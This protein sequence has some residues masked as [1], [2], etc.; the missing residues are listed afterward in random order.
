MIHKIEVP[1][2]K[3]DEVDAKSHD[4][5]SSNI[6]GDTDAT[7]SVICEADDEEDEMDKGDGNERNKEKE[8]SMI[9][10]IDTG[11]MTNL[12]ISCEINTG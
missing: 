7:E 3:E 4:G 12:D 8:E 5:E 10:K 2:N 11:E 6:T 9:C 1:E